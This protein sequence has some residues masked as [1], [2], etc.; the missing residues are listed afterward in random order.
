MQPLKMRIL[1]KFWDCQLYRGRLY[2]FTQA[3]SVLVINWDALVANIAC[4]PELVIA[5]RCAFSQG[6][7]LY[8]T[9]LQEVVNDSEVKDLML[10]K[11]ARLP[12][13]VA[14][15]TQ[16]DLSPFILHERK[17]PFPF[18]HMDS[19]IYMNTMYVSAQTGVFSG[20][21]GRTL[22]YGVSTRP[23]K[24]WDCPV[25]SIS[26]S[27]ATLALAAGSEGLFQRSL[28]HSG[29][30]QTPSDPVLVAALHCGQCDWSFHSLFGSST[31]S[32]GFLADFDKTADTADEFR[33]GPT[34]RLRAIR[35]ASTIFEGEG[36]G[37]GAQDKIY[38]VRGRRLLVCRYAPWP[39]RRA[40]RLQRIGHV[41]FLPQKGELI[42]ARVALF[43]VVL[44]FQNAIVVVPSDDG[45]PYTVWGEPV[46][47]RVF[48]RSRR[49]ENHLHVITSDG[50]DV[51]SFN[52]DYFIDQE[53]KKSGMRYS[54]LRPR[55]TPQRG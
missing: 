38:Q 18:P 22:T 41:D 10:S 6:D 53:S 24:E 33:P 14:T 54:R 35:R 21:V 17:S 20:S 5:T 19:T 46:A 50:L 2:L 40:P 45:E 16:D 4:P 44:E 23:A 11:F 3:G 9:Q 28:S 52:H 36:Y 26:A 32:G 7:I 25:T 51:F 42:S 55:A 27:Y 8:G 47:W 29:Y 1:G 15:L 13:L 34:R 49:Y 37:L 12:S 30:N 43:G 48:P 31:V 39:D